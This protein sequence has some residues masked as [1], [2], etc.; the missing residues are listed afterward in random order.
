MKPMEEDL[1]RGDHIWVQEFDYFG[2]PLQVRLAEVL[3]VVKYTFDSVQYVSV[4]YLDGDRDRRYD[5]V[6]MEYVK[7]VQKEDPGV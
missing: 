3:N 7:A 4:R 6:P 5:C 2:D 1:K